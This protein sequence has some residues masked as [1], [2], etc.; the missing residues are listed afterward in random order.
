MKDETNNKV[1]YAVLHKSIFYPGV[2]HLKETLTN[3]N[4]GLNRAVEMYAYDTYLLIKAPIRDT[5]NTA[6]V[7]V[8]LV[9]VAYFVLE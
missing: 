7:I 3:I 2:G 6:S 1:K 4:D 5:K 9:N 8:P